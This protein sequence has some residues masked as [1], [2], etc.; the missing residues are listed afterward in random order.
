MAKAI[1]SI[2][3]N[4]K[5]LLTNIAVLATSIAVL[6]L[7]SEGILRMW[8]EMFG[9]L[10]ANT[11]LTQYKMTP[12]GIF[13]HDPVL[14]MNFMKPNFTTENYWNGYRWHHQT[15]N[16]GFRNTQTRY[17]ADI[18]LLG[19]SLI[20]GHGMN[21][22]ETVGVLLER[23]TPYS[24]VNLGVQGYSAFQEAYLVTEYVP[25]FKPRYVFFF[26]FEND[27][28]DLYSFLTDQ[29]MNEFIHQNIGEV[30]YKPR[31]DPDKLI[32]RRSS[33]DSALR[34]KCSRIRTPSQT[35]ERSKQAGRP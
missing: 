20:Y 15:D 5:R 4:Y 22:D 23:R 10:F 18:L 12:E 14:K 27:I 26:F 19:D 11:V 24:V 33:I 9:Q 1:V 28:V 29:E 34:Q 16:L 25:R 8:P 7:L 3:R 35:E 31:T 6:L 17:R 32:Q 2:L 30:S 21:I 13:Y